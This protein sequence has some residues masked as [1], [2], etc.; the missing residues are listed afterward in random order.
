MVEL[1]QA[2][3]ASTDVVAASDPVELGASS[4]D[5]SP[6]IRLNQNSALETD[7]RRA[8]ASLPGPSFVAAVGFGDD[9]AIEVLQGWDRAK[10]AEGRRVGRKQQGDGHTLSDADSVPETNRGLTGEDF[11]FTSLQQFGHC[12]A[13]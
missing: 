10:E 13:D 3:G 9:D 4:N 11:G 7:V 2:A 8:D 1:K 12:E 5:A 6:D